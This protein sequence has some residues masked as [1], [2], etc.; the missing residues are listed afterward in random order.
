MIYFLH[1]LEILG[2][3]GDIMV[4]GGYNGRDLSSAEVVALG[5]GTRRCTKHIVPLPVVRDSVVAEAG[6]PDREKVT[7]CGGQRVLTATREC[8]TYLIGENRWRTASFRLT[9]V[10]KDAASVILDNGTMMVFGGR[11]NIARRF[12]STELIYNTTG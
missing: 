8:Y 2:S 3:I 1:V 6:F 11:G 5:D 12:S 7:V 9:T 4:I 10:R